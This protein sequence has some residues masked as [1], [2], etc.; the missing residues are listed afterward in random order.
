VL[1]GKR[2]AYQRKVA[3]A[4]F[5]AVV[6]GDIYVFAPRDD[7]LLPELLPFIFLSERYFQYAVETS[8][9]SLSPRTRWKHLAKFEFDL[10]PLDQQRCIAEVLW[11]VDEAYCEAADMTEKSAM[12][13]RSY[14]HSVFANPNGND[15]LPIRGTGFVQLGR[16]RS[17]KHQTGIMAKP[18]LRVANV[19]DAYFDYNDVLKMDF[20]KRDFE[21]YCLQKGDILLN[22]G[23]SRELVGRCA[24]FDGAIEDCCFQNTL[25]RYRAGG[26]V[27]TEYAYAYF[28]YCFN[29]GVFAAVA[30]QTTSVAHLGADRFGAL[31]M[32]VPPKEERG[33]IAHEYRRL[34][35]TEFCLIR[36]LKK[37]QDFQKNIIE[38]LM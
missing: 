6:S 16:Q 25:I 15:C 18:Y 30:S 11:A 29:F 37:I 32:P 2:R 27:L 12:F 35:Q 34:C 14:L 4:E 19:F 28:Q 24:I 36:H 9:G 17:P 23:Q 31:L 1:F 21:T 8:A 5:D 3:V 33:K 22:E 13:R 10:P 26:K 38:S 20:D 7:R